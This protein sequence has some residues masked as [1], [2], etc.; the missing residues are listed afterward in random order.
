MIVVVAVGLLAAVV[1][2][3][4]R[5]YLPHRPSPG[6]R[7]LRVTDMIRVALAGYATDALGHTFPRAIATWEALRHVVNAHS[8][9][10]KPHAITL[11]AT[12]AEQGFALRNYSPSDA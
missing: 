8:T 4:I 12:E 10:L 3:Q 9:N 11:K 7:A 5:P 6:T 2:I 1:A